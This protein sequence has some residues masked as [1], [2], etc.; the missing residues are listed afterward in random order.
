[1]L[2]GH[3]YYQMNSLLELIILDPFSL[4]LK[5]DVIV[6]NIKIIQMFYYIV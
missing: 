6:G 1:M 2:I 5:R 3:P 4:I